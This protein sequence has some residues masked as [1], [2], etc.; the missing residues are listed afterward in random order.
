[1]KFFIGL[2][3]MVSVVAFAQ[4]STEALVITEAKIFAPMKGSNTTA[5]YGKIQNT[6]SK[7]IA[8]KVIKANP[9]KAVETHE[10]KEV[11]G[12][13]AMERVDSFK[14]PARGV[15]ELKP[16]GNHIMLFDATR[17]LKVGEEITIELSVDGQPT[18]LKFKVESR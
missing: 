3:M 1:M 6:T 4:S 10:T 2:L 18:G 8:V 13:M 14:I 17:P 15:F 11:S 16:G 5:G 7:E 9:F 12:K